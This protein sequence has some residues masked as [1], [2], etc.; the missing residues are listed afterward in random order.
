M[1]CF[2][3][4]LPASLAA[5]FTLLTLWGTAYAQQAPSALSQVRAVRLSFVQGTAT[6]KRP[7]STEWAKAS[8]NTPIQQGFS[9]ATAKGSFAEVQFENGSTVRLGEL[10]RVDFSELALAPDGGKVNHVTFYEGY[11][12]FHFIPEHYDEYL[13]Q[14]SGVT[15][16]PH[17]KAEFRIDLSQPQL[18]V[19]V[20]DGEVQVVDSHQSEKLGK[21]KVLTCDADAAMPFRIARGI[22][23]DSWDK[24]VA[25]RDE[26]STLAYN[27][28]AVSIDAPTYGWDDLDAYG[29]WG[30]FPGYGYGWA[31][32]EPFGWAPYGLGMWSWYPGWG[33]TWISGEPWGWMP[34]HYGM[35]NYDASMGWFWMP[36]SFGMWDPASVDWY[37]EPGWIGWVPMGIGGGTPCTV[38]AVGCVTAVS[39]GTFGLGRPIRPGGPGIVQPDPTSPIRRLSSPGVEPSHLAMLSGQP[40]SKEV[41]FPGGPRGALISGDGRLLS[42]T[43]VAG[44]HGGALTEQ[45][46]AGGTIRS[47]G[48]GRAAAPGGILRAAGFERGPTAAPSSV[49]MGRTVSPD[50]VLAHH[51]FFERAFG[52]DARPARVPL[53]ETLGGRAPTVSDAHGN[54]MPRSFSSA[55]RAAGGYRGP[56][57]I[58]GL[59]FSRSS[60]GSARGGGFGGGSVGM[61]RSGGMGGGRFSGGGLGGSFHGGGMAAGGGGHR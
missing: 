56:A 55:G 57:R 4:A 9:V 54:L 51:S 53:G 38:G 37:S 28:S 30:D 12:T 13:V 49:V 44:L 7:G 31:P 48:L 16:T 19:E 6:V 26:E 27:D 11:S 8:V 17:G 2:V 45:P 46:E 23:K 15:V 21:D 5:G 39:P 61:A 25:A 1:K 20:S 33:Y 59:A 34:F 52:G 60:G 22:E 18:R 40:L 14:V 24:W 10:S 47:T 42:A 3:S 58:G 50:T 29:D 35:W 43:A 32:Y 41:V 36:G